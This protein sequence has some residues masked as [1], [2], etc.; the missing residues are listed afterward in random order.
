MIVHGL[1]WRSRVSCS[2][3]GPKE[4]DTPS[5]PSFEELD[6]LLSLSALLS[7]RV[8]ARSDKGDK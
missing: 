5:E 4:Q 8:L 3:P 7:P 2:R 6:V 1:D